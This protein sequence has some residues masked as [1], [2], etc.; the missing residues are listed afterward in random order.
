MIYDK[1]SGVGSTNNIEDLT[2]ILGWL[3]GKSYL[4]LW[5]RRINRRLYLAFSWLF[6]L[7]F[8]LGVYLLLCGIDT[9]EK[10]V[11]EVSCVCDFFLF[12]PWRCR[13]SMSLLHRSRG[14]LLLWYCDSR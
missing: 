12:V 10:G 1:V 11:E 13:V 2:G 7:V 6:F 3:Y 8:V 4:I 9:R 5:G 14:Q